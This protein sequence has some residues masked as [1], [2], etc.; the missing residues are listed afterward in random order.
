MVREGVPLLM[1][2]DDEPAQRRLVSAL[3]ARAGWRT[4]FASDAETALATLGTQDGMQLDAVL[5]DQ[6]SPDFDP[7]DLIGAIH[8]QRPAL[9]ILVLTAHN[10]VAV[11]VQAMR[12]GAT[13]YLSKPIAPE[14]LL[15][16]LNATLEG[17][18]RG[19]LRPLTEKIS[20]PLAFEDVVGA[21]PQFRTALAIAAK[22]ARARVPVLIEGE[23]GVGKDVVA[24]AIHA[25]SP[26]HKQAMVTVNCGAIPA[27]LVESEL[28]GHERGA[29]TGAFDRHV[30]KF[31]SADMGT[32]F[33]DEVSEMPLDAQVKLLRVLQDGEVQPIGARRPVHVDVRVIAATNKK[34]SDEIEAGRFRED[35]YYRLNVVQ[36]TVPP[37]RERM[38]DIPALCRHLL[39][40]IATQPGL[41]GL[42][43]TDDALALLMQHDWP[44]NVRQLQNA[45][46]RAAVLCEGDALTPHDFPQVAA[47]ILS[48]GAS[49]PRQRAAA[50]PPREA[51]GITLFEGDGHVRQLAEIE[52]DVIRL[53]IGHYRGRMTEVARRL[54]IGRSTLYRKLAELGID[55][56]A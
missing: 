28:F 32:I 43:L 51:A 56:A 40:R 37:L 55:N 6:W 41:R 8:A 52:A 30:G 46:F 16:A 20:A 19:E 11:A 5:I 42:G 22:A 48:R 4:I 45:L 25:A 12:A 1:L 9:P 53:A 7:A 10:S 21:A 39:A 38:G 54:G 47:H 34:L 26:R 24:R 18:V 14:R 15:A 17:N 36:L 35:L 44:G 50:T 2:I 27:N 3:A 33:L 13:D 23:S 29:F 49:G 31:L